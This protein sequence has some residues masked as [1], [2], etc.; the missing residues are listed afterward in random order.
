MLIQ[1]LQ[2]VN[3]LTDNWKQQLV[4]DFVTGT[5]DAD[6]EEDTQEETHFAAEPT[7]EPEFLINNVH[8]AEALKWVAQLKMFT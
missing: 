8:V 5:R 2:P 7:T 4:D 3:S 1:T 6:C